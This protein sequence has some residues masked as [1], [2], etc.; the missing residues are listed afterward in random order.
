MINW[1]HCSKDDVGPGWKFL[2]D[3]LEWHLD[4]VPEQIDVIQVKEKFGGLRF[5]VN[6]ETELL[7]IINIIESIS[8]YVCE[9]CGNPGKL[10]TSRYW[11][12]TLC[13][14]CSNIRNTRP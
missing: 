2:L 4:Q 7:E 12:K 11:M 9:Q 14:D 13:S 3:L 8:Q 6:Y 10:D 1:G 5:Y